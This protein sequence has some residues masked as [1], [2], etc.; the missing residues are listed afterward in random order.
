MR[1]AARYAGCCDLCYTPFAARQWILWDPET[2]FVRCRRRCPPAALEAAR[3]RFQGSVT[4]IVL[5][6]ARDNGIRVHEWDTDATR[7]GSLAWVLAPT[8]RALVLAAE[9]STGPDEAR[10]AG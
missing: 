4:R 3:A 1:I 9:S 6:Y 2:G 5:E 7:R 10:A 8:L